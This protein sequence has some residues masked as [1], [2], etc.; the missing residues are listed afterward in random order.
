MLKLKHKLTLI[1][2]GLFLLTS[3]APSHYAAQ[4]QSSFKNHTGHKTDDGRSFTVGDE[5]RLEE[6][7]IIA[8]EELKKDSPPPQKK[9]SNPSPPSQSEDTE[10][11]SDEDQKQKVTSEEFPFRRSLKEFRF[12]RYENDPKTPAKLGTKSYSLQVYIQPDGSAGA[13]VG[14]AGALKTDGAQL[15]FEDS[16]Q[17]NEDYRVKGS[18]ESV[19]QVVVGRFEISRKGALKGSLLETATVLYKAYEADLNVRTPLDKNLEEYVNLNKKVQNLKADTKAWVNDFVVPFGVSTFDVAIIRKPKTPGAEK[20]KA[21]SWEDLLEFKGRSVETDSPQTEDLKIQALLSDIEYKSM[22]LIGNAEGEDSKIFSMTVKDDKG[23]DTELL[24]DVER[25]KSAAE[26]EEENKKK[27][28]SGVDSDTNSE[29]TDGGQL[30][31][32][33][34]EVI[35]DGTKSETQTI[36]PPPQEPAYEKEEETTPFPIDIEDVPIPV[37]RPTPPKSPSAP[38]GSQDSPSTSR[39]NNSKSYMS[40]SQ[41]GMAA[42]I[43]R[44]F[45]ATFN[46]KGVQD[47]IRNINGN[48]GERNRLKSFFKYAN[49]FRGLI[50]SIAK[51]YRVPPQFAYVAVIESAYFTG[52]NYVVQISSSESSTGPFQINRATAKHLGMNFVYN[53]IGVMPP[54]RDERRYFAPSACAGAKYF[55]ENAEQFPRDYS[56]SVL[57]YNQGAGGTRGYARKYGYTYAEISRHNFAGARYANK[58]LAAYFIAGNYEN[59]RY[60]VDSASPRNLPSRTVFP[61]ARIKDPKCRKATDAYR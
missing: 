47:A 17:T 7:K 42:K 8:I 51:E 53:G 34:D 11:G 30:P 28:E 15:L 9:N 1:G 50:S 19:E 56:L 25:P 23:N 54:A 38:K 61:A 10:E 45:D 40:T 16:S 29:E 57:A 31:P 6:E 46:L 20:P 18:L 14:F 12:L 58:K 24:L 33:E 48:K 21:D 49:P 55:F 52:G 39:G 26:I 43:V 35:V 60:D 41:S 32:Q 37:K 36:L 2:A 3:C 4:D 22:Q 59:S 13:W 44:A 27:L 5:P